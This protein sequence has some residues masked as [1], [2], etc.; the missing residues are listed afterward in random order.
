M[1]IGFDV[2]TNDVPITPGYYWAK[3]FHKTMIVKVVQ[4]PRIS[5]MEIVGVD[6]NTHSESFTRIDTM[7]NV[8]WCGPIKEPT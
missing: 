7:K 6:S 1:I 3:F 8:E 4:R 2:Y 5:F